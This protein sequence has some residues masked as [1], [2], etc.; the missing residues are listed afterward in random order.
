MYYR[1]RRIIHRL[2]LKPLA[3][4][5][6]GLR[7][8]GAEE[9]T[10]PGPAIVVANHN[11]HLDTVL[12]LA[13]FPTSTINRV[14]P[15]AAADYFLRNRLISWFST[16]IIGVIPL[17]RN[18][19]DQIDPLRGA[20]EALAAGEVLILYP[21][22]TRGN[23]GEFAELK[24]GVARLA[25]RHPGVPIIP[26]WLD[27]CDKAMPKGSK[28]PRPLPCQLTVGDSIQLRT[29]E[30]ASEF[31]VRLRQTMLSLTEHLEIAA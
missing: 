20:S 24:S 26:V 22:G 7:V 23:A 14:R 27:G 5:L 30:S 11:S 6:F 8:E 1:L 9:L 18:K 10:D 3:R 17:E 13:A 19:R 16:R 25:A 21:E 12:L 2:V 29:G 28:L 15:V 4:V 31:L